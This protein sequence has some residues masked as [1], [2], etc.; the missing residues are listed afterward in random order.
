MNS[1]RQGKTKKSKNR[2]KPDFSFIAVSLSVLAVLMFLNSFF[3]NRNFQ[4]V[5]DRF[6]RS[7][8]FSTIENIE[9]LY[10]QF[11]NNQTNAS[12]VLG[13][14]QELLNAHNVELTDDDYTELFNYAGS[15]MMQLSRLIG[16]DWLEQQEFAI[17]ALAYILSQ[18]GRI[19]IHPSDQH[20]DYADKLFFQQLISKN[21]DTGM[22]LHRVP[23][24]SH[25]KLY[26]MFYK[27]NHELG[28]YTILDI[29]QQ[30]YHKPIKSFLNHLILV[31]V[32][33]YILISLGIYT[34]YYLI[35]R[36]ILY[37]R[38]G[39]Q[40]ILSGKPFELEQS[41][42]KSETG[43]MH[44]LTIQL[45]G[46]IHTIA[47][48]LK[49]ISDNEAT[50]KNIE[51]PEQEYHNILSESLAEAKNQLKR[52]REQEKARN[53]ENEK[54]NW[55]AKGIAKFSDI[56]R[57]NNELAPMGEQLMS[58]LASYL[59]VNQCGLFTINT[60]DTKEKNRVLTLIAVHAYDRSRHLH[61]EI[62]FGDGLV[63]E[64]AKE[65]KAKIINK[66]PPG[67]LHITSGLGQATPDYLFLMPLIYEE[68]VLGVIEIA[69]FKPLTENETAFLEQLSE[70]IASAITNVL[71]NEN[72]NKLLRETREQAE[73][74][75]SQEEEMRQT[76]E[77]LQATQEEMNRKSKQAEEL[78]KQFQQKE[79]EYMSLL[80]KKDNEIK[81]LK[82]SPNK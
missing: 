46:F 26:R 47:D 56:I 39:L 29:E 40:A 67:Y 80:K 9:N 73:R 78:N 79:K 65:G 12:Y 59:D 51:N 77:E 48:E 60:L 31:S 45:N 14:M 82:S 25:G 76:M 21:D 36:R 7:S 68:R 42:N 22:L 4:S 33:F 20:R 18:D 70:I 15:T 8:I 43:I 72:T 69:S 50:N 54:Q 55:I 17:D 35:F 58:N 34:A 13:E 41:G 38:Q 75:A 49:N 71:I 61:K 6:I 62:K 2:V 24:T 10:F 16:K 30:E 81:K 19:I 44:N 32:V 53:E 63:G 23:E 11:N 28:T 74:M 5:Y 66:I 64:C 37:I 52:Y 3:I 27:H 57:R 1:N